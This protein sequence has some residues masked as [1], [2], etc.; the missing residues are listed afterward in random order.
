MGSYTTYRISFKDFG[1]FLDLH[2]CHLAYSTYSEYPSMLASKLRRFS[3][4]RFN[5][6]D[7]LSCLVGVCSCYLLSFVGF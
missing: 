4:D 1:M 2:E 7:V 6:G 5:V 3:P